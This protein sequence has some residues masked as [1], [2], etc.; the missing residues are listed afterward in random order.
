MS[1]AYG[2]G[3][4]DAE[5]EGRG[6]DSPFGYVRWTE[7]RNIEAF[8]DLVADGRVN[9]QTLITHRFEL[10]ETDRAYKLI[11]GEIKEPYLG[12]VMKYDT[13]RGLETRIPIAETRARPELTARLR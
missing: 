2:P 12:I 1:M 7:G 10:S 13:E 11:M 9:V 6:H 4:Y 8:L 5:Y 3:R